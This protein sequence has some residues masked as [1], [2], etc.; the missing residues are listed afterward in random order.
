VGDAQGYLFPPVW[1]ADSFSNGAGMNRLLMAMRFIKH[2]MPLGVD[3]STP[4]LSDE[5]AFDVA[6]FILSK[7]RPEKADLDKD[8]PARW[9]KPIDAAFP[10]YVDGAP[11]D[12][13]KYGPFP[14]L[15][16]NA[17]KL[18]AEHAQKRKAEAK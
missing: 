11:A 12:Q 13:H 7:P 1:G 17:R 14:P 16:E 15:A 2:N 4:Q 18:A 9:N 6:A 10:P 5:Q 3:H 8:F